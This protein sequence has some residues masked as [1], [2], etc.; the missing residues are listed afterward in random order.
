MRRDYFHN[1]GNP[2]GNVFK[3]MKLPNNITLYQ[4]RER[5][6]QSTGRTL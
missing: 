6:A 2:A 5:L 1:L 4:L 3:K